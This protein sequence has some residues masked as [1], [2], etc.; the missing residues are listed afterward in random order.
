MIGKAQEPSKSRLLDAIRG[1]LSEHPDAYLIHVSLS[2][3]AIDE[4]FGDRS[5]PI[6]WVA[7]SLC[8][9]TGESITES[10]LDFVGPEH[11]KEELERDFQDIFP[12]HQI[13]VDHDVF[14]DDE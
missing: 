11:T 6:K 1:A 12:K 7:W 5:R 9:D 2:E 8:D 4:C 14:F 3:R 10:K 13:Y